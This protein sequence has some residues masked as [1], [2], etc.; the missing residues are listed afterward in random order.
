MHDSPD[1]A[2]RTTNA[3]ARAGRGLLRRPW[4]WLVLIALAAGGYWAIDFV[5][6]PVTADGARGGGGSSRSDTRIWAISSSPGR[7][8]R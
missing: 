2:E 7:R 5:R 4:F 8:S 3:P 6:Q 1:D